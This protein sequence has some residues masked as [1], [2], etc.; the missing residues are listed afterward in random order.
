MH[1]SRNYA[2]GKT[3]PPGLNIIT[4]TMPRVWYSSWKT[5]PDPKIRG[6]LATNQRKLASR[7]ALIVLAMTVS[8]NWGA[9][10]ALSQKAQHYHGDG[11]DSDNVHSDGDPEQSNQGSNQ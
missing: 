3:F 7:I 2:S 4:N 5:Q 11:Q 8:F 10:L 1:M 9:D 6:I